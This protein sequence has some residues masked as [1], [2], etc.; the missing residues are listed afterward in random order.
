MAPHYISLRPSSGLVPGSLR[1]M[2]NSRPQ[3]GEAS[4]TFDPQ[5]GLVRS[6]GKVNLEQTGD[7]GSSMEFEMIMEHYA[8]WDPGLPEQKTASISAKV[9]INAE[10][11]QGLESFIVSAD[12]SL[13]MFTD[14]RV[15]FT[16]TVDYLDHVVT[17]HSGPNAASGNPFSGSQTRSNS[18]HSGQTTYAGGGS[19]NWECP[20]VECREET[21]AKATDFLLKMLESS[22]ELLRLTVTEEPGG[23]DFCLGVEVDPLEAALAPG[24][25][26]LPL[27][28]Q[29]TNWNEDPV[30]QAQVSAPTAKL[31]ILLP[32]SGETGADGKFSY[33]YTSDE[34]GTETVPISV[35]Y[36]FYKQEE[37]ALINIQDLWHFHMD[38]IVDASGDVTFSFDQDF[39]IG[40]GG[41]LVTTDRGVGIITSDWIDWECFDID[42]GTS[43]PIQVLFDS[44]FSFDLG[45]SYAPEAGEAGS[46]KLTL[47]GDKP[48]FITTS[49]DPTCNVEDEN[50]MTLILG[51]FAQDPFLYLTQETVTVPAV[52]QSQQNFN[53]PEFKTSA[54]IEIIR[55]AGDIP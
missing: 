27:Q 50:I 24:G 22:L 11:D 7:S 47:K 19:A 45:G 31:G 4:Q 38:Y 51:G 8:C 26:E 55:Q 5:T 1:D 9:K 30:D 52:H 40:P 23:D 46:F 17:V 34:A 33:T 25:E 15:E 37:Q 43:W 12:S 20:P 18:D 44:A 49:N 28:V 35:E 41:Q 21:L 48:D 29:V 14:G 13:T 42:N 2:H 32:E 16:T 3:S 53:A 10:T 36:S 6:E 54:T 39:S